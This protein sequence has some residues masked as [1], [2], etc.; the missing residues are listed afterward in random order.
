VVAR[1]GYGVAGDEVRVMLAVTWADYDTAF[2]EV[3][4]ELVGVV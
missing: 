1:P 4:E 3:V 2:S